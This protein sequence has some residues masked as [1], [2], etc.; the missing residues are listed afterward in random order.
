M[1][2]RTLARAEPYHK[3]KCGPYLP[4]RP[5]TLIPDIQLVLLPYN[6]LLQKTAREA[7]GIDLTDQVVIIDEAHSML[8]FIHSA[9]GRSSPHRSHV[10]APVSIHHQT[11]APYPVER[12]ASAL[13]LPDSLQ[14]STVHDSLYPLEASDEPTRGTC[15]IR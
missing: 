15:Q 13:H 12:T 4:G 6:L 8:S 11:A 2:A 1:F 5:L 14:K 3:L 7:L 10:Y 9:T